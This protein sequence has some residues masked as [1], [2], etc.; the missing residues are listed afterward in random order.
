MGICGNNIQRVKIELDGKII[1]LV[2]EFKYLE[3]TVSFASKGVGF[4]I[5]TY[6]K[7]N[8]IIRRS[9]GKQMFRGIQLR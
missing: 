1:K 8:G 9:F 7:T 3:N 6:N 2:S 5:Q 4:K